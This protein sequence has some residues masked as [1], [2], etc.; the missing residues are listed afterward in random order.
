MLEPELRRRFSLTEEAVA[1]LRQDD[2]RPIKGIEKLVEEALR[3]QL[4]E[5][6]SIEL[7]LADP[8]A[9]K[10][11]VASPETD[12]LPAVAGKRY[13]VHLA[14]EERRKSLILH[15]DPELL[16]EAIA[17]GDAFR[18][19]ITA[20]TIE[21]D[22]GTQRPIWTIVSRAKGHLRLRE[23]SYVCV[24]GRQELNG[25]LRGLRELPEGGREFRV[26][27]KSTGA[28]RQAA[29][30]QANV[31][32][33]IVIIND[34]SLGILGYK[35]ARMDN[36]PGPGEWLTHRTPGGPR[37]RVVAEAAQDPSSGPPGDDDD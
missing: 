31:S 10:P 13:L 21:T 11:F 19:T 37:S 16:D 18:G 33:E 3:Q 36:D 1:R 27:I 35:I 30:S 34:S 25:I 26:A 24:A 28:A 23:E 5:Y 29:T 8:D 22:G 20:V 15:N 6:T 4:Q 2:R 9:A 7:R 32:E 17:S 14:S 12:L